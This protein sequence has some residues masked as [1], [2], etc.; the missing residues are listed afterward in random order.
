M[1]TAT[2][3][4]TNSKSSSFTIDKLIGGGGNGDG[5]K[6]EMASAGSTE[7]SRKSSPATSPTAAA[8]ATG[9]A[10]PLM[11]PAAAVWLR[12]LASFQRAAAVAGM[13]VFPGFPGVVGAGGQ[14]PPYLHPGMGAGGAVTGAAD[15][16]RYRQFFV[17][18][19]FP[20]WPPK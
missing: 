10:V 18:N 9:P 1:V 5:Q 13:P 7:N 6:S 17:Q 20:M 3:K 19:A 16:E 11:D 2:P 12:N 8:T 4:T 14:V 15:M